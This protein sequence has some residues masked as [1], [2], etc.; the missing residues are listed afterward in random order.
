MLSR[1]DDQRMVMID[2]TEKVII[3]TGFEKAAGYVKKLTG[4][5]TQLQTNKSEATR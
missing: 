1:L 4:I 3:I 5:I 2:Q